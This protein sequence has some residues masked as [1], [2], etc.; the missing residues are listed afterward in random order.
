MKKLITI[1]VLA[2]IGMG[3]TNTMNAQ[4]G[5]SCSSAKNLNTSIALISD[6]IDSGNELYYKFVAIDTSVEI[7]INTTK[8]YIT[9]S[10][11]T[12]LNLL[13]GACGMLTKIASD[14]ALYS[15]DSSLNI[16][17][18]GL[19]IGNTYFIKINKLIGT[20]KINFNLIAK[21]FPSTSCALT[22]CNLISDGD[23]EWLP[24]VSGNPSIVGNY[25]EIW[26]ACSWRNPSLATPDLF[27]GLATTNSSYLTPTNWRGTQ[28]DYDAT[29]PD[30]NYAG[31][32]A[33]YPLNP[34]WHEYIY[35]QLPNLAPNTTYRVRMY[36][37]LADNSSL[38]TNSL[39]FLFSENSP[40]S[41]AYYNLSGQGQMTHTG[42][43]FS[44]GLG[45]TMYFMPMMGPGT[46]GF[47]N[48]KTQWMPV[49]QIFTTPNSGGPLK[50]L[51]IGDFESNNTVGPLHYEGATDPSMPPLP[52][53]YEAAF[54]YIDWVTLEIEHGATATAT[55]NTILQNCSATTSQLNVV[56]TG[57]GLGTLT[58]S[59]LPTTGLSNPSIANPI[60]NP[61]TTTNYTVTVTSTNFPSC[62]MSSVVTVNVIS[63]P[64][65]SNA[66]FSIPQ[67]IG[68]TASNP[69]L[70]SATSLS[71]FISGSGLSAIGKTINISGVVKFDQSIIKFND[72]NIIMEPGAQLIV[73]GFEN[74][75]LTNFTHIHSCCQMWEGITLRDQSQF[76]MD[77]NAMIEDADTAIVNQGATLFDIN[78]GIFNKNYKAIS[79]RNIPPNAT[80]I[81]IQGSVFTSRNI[82][83]NLNPLLDPT[84]T[85]I[86]SNLNTYLN[87]MMLPPMSGS[88]GIYGIDVWSIASTSNLTIGVPLAPVAG[89][90]RENWFD[91]L[92]T[93][94]TLYHSTASIYN[95]RFLYMPKPGGF[96]LSPLAGIGINC[97]GYLN[98]NYSV[99]VG[100]IASYHKNYFYDDYIGIRM[101]LYNTAIV[102]NNDFDNPSTT[103]NS[104]MTWIH[105]NYGVYI[106]NPSH[107]YWFPPNTNSFTIDKNNI[108]NCVYGVY[109]NRPVLNPANDLIIIDANHIEANGT[110]TCYDGVYLQ[111]ATGG[112]YSYTATDNIKVKNNKIINAYNCVFASNIQ[113]GLMIRRNPTL[114]MS[115]DNT[116]MRC[117]VNIQSCKNV[118]IKENCDISCVDMS[119]TNY[120]S[121][122]PNI[123]GIY[124]KS[125]LNF[126]ITDNTMDYTRASIMFEGDCSSPDAVNPNL[127]NNYFGNAY[128]GLHMNAGAKIGTQGFPGYWSGAVG[129]PSRNVWN[130]WNHWRTYVFNSSVPDVNLNSRL[131]VEGSV[132]GVYVPSNS[133]HSGGAGAFI[134]TTLTNCN[135]SGIWQLCQ[136]SGVPNPAQ[137]SNCNTYYPGMAMNGGN[138]MSLLEQIS[139]LKGI[140]N[141]TAYILSFEEATKW[142]NLKYVYQELDDNLA[143]VNG[144]TILQKFYDSTMNQNIGI[145]SEIERRMKEGDFIYA[146]NLNT[147]ST[148]TKYTEAN[149]KLINYLLMKQVL[150]SNYVYTSQ[151]SADA[152]SLASQCADIGGGAV[153][154]ARALYN[155]IINDIEN[156]EDLC[157][158]AHRSCLISTTSSEVS[159]KFQLY[160]NPNNGIMT[161]E[162]KLKESENGVLCIYDITGRIV[163]NHYFN[164]SNTSVILDETQLNAGTYFYDIKIN[165]SEVK[166]DKLI[167]AK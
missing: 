161:L 27:S 84:V 108:Y 6:S 2:L 93:G 110:R 79:I 112:G 63:M 95:N 158:E 68:G 94:I 70:S 137:Y 97:I 105:G 88:K 32:A 18:G 59:W 152:Y 145:F 89:V 127:F 133:Q 149:Q 124:V 162:Y 62:P 138:T 125:T 102:E 13:S 117:G 129:V 31:I 14:T 122:T 66:V 11:L 92:G 72:C 26:R 38:E 123:R 130:S 142:M 42:N 24:P 81:S 147:S 65:C 5:D 78:G 75:T 17:S 144:D 37:N 3:W 85:Q 33:Y 22:G 140:L 20:N 46:G 166:K 73:N 114:K 43:T 67:V 21:W 96:N 91:N 8:K 165:G 25:G 80:T 146:D 9:S 51:T 121:P 64:S 107:A 57:T 49:E 154:Q 15:I 155:Y 113:N 116:A 109:V 23:F 135:P 119:T 111:D 44:A 48:S 39:G 164:S 30:G 143:L 10:Y 126:N 50:Y 52:I 104:N 36:V 87:A 118:K 40:M 29:A 139:K 45:T 82:P 16:T 86:K 69:V 71:A 98:R 131:C 4:S 132:G 106:S 100:S 99:S 74:L 90:D 141:D 77:G 148:P 28:N 47:Y 160:P 120:Q 136:P 41:A 167:I 35:Q 12:S 76:V 153:W 157:T 83:T 150:D 134:Y 56:V 163:S 115:F 61:S 7:T 101:D 54:Y 128:Y 19:I 103:T 60:A 159:R 1:I 58:Y 53:T 156:F 34:G 55:P 151:D